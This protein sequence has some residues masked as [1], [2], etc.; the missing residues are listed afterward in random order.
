MEGL[1]AI[2]NRFKKW[3]EVTVLAFY[4]DCCLL[5]GEKQEQKPSIPL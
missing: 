1:Q 4:K 3:H 5:N 2:L